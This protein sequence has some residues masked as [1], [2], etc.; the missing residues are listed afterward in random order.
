MKSKQVEEPIIDMGEIEAVKQVSNAPVQQQQIQSRGKIKKTVIQNN[1]DDLISPLRD[2][3]ITVRHLPQAGMISDPKHVLYGGMAETATFTV[4]VP[5]LRS[6]VFVDVLTK[7]EKRY[8]EAAMG[9]EEGAMNVYNKVNNFWD[10]NTEGGISRVRLTK[11]GTKL[12]LNDPTDYIR[13]KI[14][15]ANKDLICPDLQTLQDK[16]KATYR[17]VL[18]SNN[19]VNQTAKSKM[20]T[21][22]RA[23]AEYGKH[24]NDT[25]ILRAVIEL[26]TGKPLASNTK[27]DF[28]QTKAG[29]LID[30]D[31]KLFL[32][33]ITDP[34]LPTKILIK[35][36]VEE[37]FISKRGDYLYLREDNTPLCE[38]GEEPTL[39]MAAKYLANP[40]RQSIKLSLEAKVNQ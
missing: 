8:L 39:T 14:L 4:C 38:G 17:F 27:L 7:S 34:L 26:I 16:P 33:I 23:Y 6:G 18:V 32:S 5:R 11:M 1:P 19:E 9:L 12:Y 21:K 24:E 29:E 3:V 20:T 25:D 37:G 30:A 31:S 28:L 22:M 10:N 15:L 36:C 13:Y 40:K 2:T 35:K